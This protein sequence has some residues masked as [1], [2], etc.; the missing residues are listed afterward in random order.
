MARTTSAES[1][2]PSGAQTSSIQFSTVPT[3]SGGRIT[4]MVR[5]TNWPGARVTVSCAQFTLSPAFVHAHSGCGLKLA[6]V[7]PGGS[8]SVSKSGPFHV[9]TPTLA[10][11]IVNVQTSP[12]IQVTGPV[13]RFS[14]SGCGGGS[15]GVSP[16]TTVTVGGATGGGAGGVRTSAPAQVW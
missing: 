11:V 1:S 5:L 9:A 7:A 4:S 12:A 8:V 6:S 15:V 14:K 16:V 3:I 10:T 2:G 13:L